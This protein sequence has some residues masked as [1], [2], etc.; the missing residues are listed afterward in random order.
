M[1][2][3]TSYACSLI[4]QQPSAFT[5]CFPASRSTIITA[6]PP[7]VPLPPHVPRPP[8]PLPS[9]VA[10]P[11][12]PPARFKQ[13]TALRSIGLHGCSCAMCSVITTALE[14]RARA[15]GKVVAPASECSRAGI[16]E[17]GPH[18]WE[19]QMQTNAEVNVIRA[20]AAACARDKNRSK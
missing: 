13:R 11:P 3:P 20:A 14:L 6:D 2:Q 8:F 16:D 1:E 7:C 10:L 12:Q 5:P 4:T 9:P 17:H 19:P 18:R 15:I